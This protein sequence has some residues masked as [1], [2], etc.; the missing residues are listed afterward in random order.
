MNAVKKVVGKPAVSSAA[1]ATQ[2]VKPATT[3]P[4]LA[5]NRFT[6]QDD[7]YQAHLL[8]TGSNE[9]FEDELFIEQGPTPTT[10]PV[11]SVE[12]LPNDL[13]SP[14]LNLMKVNSSAYLALEHDDSYVLERHH[15]METLKGPDAFRFLGF[16]NVPPFCHLTRQHFKYIIKKFDPYLKE[17]FQKEQEHVFWDLFQVRV[18]N[19]SNL[20][21]IGPDRIY[22]KKTVP[23]VIG[24]KQLPSVEYQGD[25]FKG[26]MIAQMLGG[27]DNGERWKEYL[28]QL[29]SLTAT[30]ELQFYA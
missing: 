4:P 18:Y 8:E 23:R 9:D 19:K 27:S 16:P 21:A 15:V 10:H 12:S 2:A 17:L 24:G 13:K 7:H 11:Q 28:I 26:H 6:D 30:E 20:V 3:T 14:Y 1:A 22:G 5:E 25:L 29:E